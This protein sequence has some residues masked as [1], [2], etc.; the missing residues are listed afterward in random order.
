MIDQ[1]LEVKFFVRDIKVVETRLLN[2]GA[3]LMQPRTH[4]TNLRFDTTNRDL[5]QSFKVLRLRQDTAARLTF[6]GPSQFL[7]GVHIRKEIE[8]VVSDFNSARKFLEE[9]GYLVVMIYEKYRTV[10]DLDKN[11]IMLDELPYGDFVEIEGQDPAGVFSINQKIG[12][13]WENHISE[14]YTVLMDRMHNELNLPFRDLV[15]ENFPD[16]K[17]NVTLLK[18]IK[19]AN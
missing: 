1:E 4:E 5:A 11:H 6:K 3:K 7:D 15:F 2:L 19:P 16:P 8:F 10:Y 12:L 18:N 17:C 9:L 14:S 13:I